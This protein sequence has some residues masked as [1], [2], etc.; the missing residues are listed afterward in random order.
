MTLAGLIELMDAF[1]RGDAIS[2]R[3]ANR[4][5]GA[6]LEFV[7]DRPELEELADELAQ[8][9]PEGGDYLFDYDYMR[10]RVAYHLRALRSQSAGPEEAG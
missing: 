6:L 9:R 10:P 3:D 4:L 1:V 2:L 8:Y 5:E 7:P